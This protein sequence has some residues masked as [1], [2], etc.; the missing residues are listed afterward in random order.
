MPERIVEIFTLFYLLEDVRF[1]K[2]T[3]LDTFVYITTG[4]LFRDACSLNSD[5]KL[6]G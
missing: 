3:R 4:L 2:S 5:M 1:L 6:S